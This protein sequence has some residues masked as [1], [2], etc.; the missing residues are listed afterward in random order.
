MSPLNYELMRKRMV[1]QQ[2]KLRGIFDDKILD[3][4]NTVPREAF[5]KPSLRRYAYED[6]PLSIDHNQ[7]ISQPYIVALMTHAIEPGKDMRVLEIGTGSGY[8]TAILAELVDQV[9]TV[10]RVEPL[11]TNAEQVLKAQGYENIRFKLADGK[12]GWPEAAPFD[13]IIVTAACKE[14]PESLIAQ[15]AE[16]GIIVIPVGGFFAQNLMKGRKVDGRLKRKDLGG[17]RFV[18]LI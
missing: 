5:I 4:F 8:Q 9:Y 18:P 15:L 17:C 11:K 1:S 2:L 14:I 7:T 12:R 6:H 10:E 13:A 3:A 16:G